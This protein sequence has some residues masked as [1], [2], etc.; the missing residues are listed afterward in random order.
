MAALELANFPQPVQTATGLEVGL[1]IRHSVS[2]SR[3]AD[4]TEEPE[5]ISFP[6]QQGGEASPAFPYALQGRTA[7]FP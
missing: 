6:P 7:N 2:L 3:R 5:G 1:G 4:Q